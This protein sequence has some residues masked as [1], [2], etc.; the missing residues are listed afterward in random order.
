MRISEEIDALDVMGIR[1]IT[2]LAA[3]RLLAAWMVLPFVYL[4]GVAWGFLASYIAVIQQVGGVS[5]GGYSLIFWEF[6]NPGDCY[7][8]SSRR[9]RWPRS[10]SSSAATTVS[11]R[12]A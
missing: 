5:T 9:W 10:S 4:G 3:T 12:A 2:F 1:S 6:Q 8:A 11:R 7:L